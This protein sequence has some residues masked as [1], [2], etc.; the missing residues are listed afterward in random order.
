MSLG[1]GEVQLSVVPVVDL[2]AR[3]VVVALPDEVVVPPQPGE[4]QAA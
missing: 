3:R 4:E 2:T 1:P